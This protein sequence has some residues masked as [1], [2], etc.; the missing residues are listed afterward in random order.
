MNAKTTNPHYIHITV[1]LTLLVAGCLAL[2]SGCNSLKMPRTLIQSPSQRYQSVTICYQFDS[3]LARASRA[4]GRG[5]DKN[6]VQQVAADTRAGDQI[7]TLYLQYPH[8]DAKPGCARVELVI[9]C[10]SNPGVT[11]EQAA[12]ANWFKRISTA[13]RDNL[14]GVS[15]GDGVAGAWALDVSTADM[16]RILKS[17]DK[18]SFFGEFLPATGEVS[19]AVRV[20]GTNVDKRWNRV[21]ELDQLSNRVK[22]QGSLV[23]HDRPVDYINVPNPGV[24]INAPNPAIN[25]PNFNAPGSVTRLPPT[26]MPWMG[27]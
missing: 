5:S 19:I 23:S 7:R 25:G 9:H 10:A 2:M 24:S 26:D 21:I 3:R 13:A 6:E 16:E 14:P 18:E 11:A 12:S 27:R 17:L 20:N 8:P 22:W 4:F 1:R 15:L